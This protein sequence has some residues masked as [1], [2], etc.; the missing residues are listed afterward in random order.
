MLGFLAR[1]VRGCIKGCQDEF[2]AYSNGN[3]ASFGAFAGLNPGDFHG[4][5]RPDGDVVALRD[6]ESILR[7]R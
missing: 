2:I 4:T 5:F 7:R 1:A 3:I 6:F